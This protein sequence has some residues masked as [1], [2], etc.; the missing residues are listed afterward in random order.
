MPYAYYMAHTEQY[1]VILHVQLPP[2]DF[3]YAFLNTNICNGRACVQHTAPKRLSTICPMSQLCVVD[4][5]KTIITFKLFIIVFFSAFLLCYN[6]K[7]YVMNL[8]WL[9]FFFFFFLS[10]CQSSCLSIFCQ[11]TMKLSPNTMNVHKI[12]LTFLFF[13]FSFAFYHICRI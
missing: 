13:F 3:R 7:I 9:F 4:E 8:Q 1:S 11:R 10:L 12:G 6:F 2:A 5:N